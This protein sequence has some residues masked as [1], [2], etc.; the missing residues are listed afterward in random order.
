[1]ILPTLKSQQF[2]LNHNR[3][4][5]EFWKPRYVSTIKEQWVKDDVTTV[6]FN[7]SVED[8]P[9]LTLMTTEARYKKWIYVDSINGDDSNDGLTKE[10]AVKTVKEAGSRVEPDDEIRII[11]LGNPD[12]YKSRI[13]NINE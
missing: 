10:T 12:T 4:W 11:N 5:W 3:K 6:E 13:R 1:M 8:D 7:F 2:E 9:L